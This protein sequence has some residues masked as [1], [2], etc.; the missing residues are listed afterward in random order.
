MNVFVYGTLRAGEGNQRLIA[1]FIQESR[2]GKVAAILLDKG[3]YP[4]AILSA[5]HAAVGEWITF[6][7]KA[8]KEVLRL[9]DRLEG[10]RGAGDPN[11]HYE[12]IKVK[13][14]ENG[15]EGWMYVVDPESPRCKWI[16]GKYPMI[17]SGDWKES[18]R[19]FA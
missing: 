4:Y 11:N 9:L 19:C 14:L 5:D 17:A 15:T 10:Y 12:R 18:A 7:K 3:A 2:P 8:E 16:T 13:D 6:D 1:R